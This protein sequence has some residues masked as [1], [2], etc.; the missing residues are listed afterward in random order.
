MGVLFLQPMWER[1]DESVGKTVGISLLEDVRIR[2]KS[3]DSMTKCEAKKRLR[4]RS[5]REKLRIKR[6]GLWDLL[7]DTYA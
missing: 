4:K 2:M 1:E 3:T 6:S 5:A 7:V